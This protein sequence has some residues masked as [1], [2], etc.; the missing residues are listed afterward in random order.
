MYEQNFRRPLDVFFCC[1]I[2]AIGSI[3]RNETNETNETNGI[4]GING[5]SEK[6]IKSNMT[7]GALV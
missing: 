2:G 6:R 4:N 7:I 3:G 5:R 1:V